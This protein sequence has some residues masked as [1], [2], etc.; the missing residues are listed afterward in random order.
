MFQNLSPNCCIT[1]AIQGGGQDEL[2]GPPRLSTADSEPFVEDFIHDGGHDEL[3]GPP[4][5]NSVDLSS[6]AFI[7]EGGQEELPGPP[8]P[9]TAARLATVDSSGDVLSQEGGQEELPGPPRS[10]R[11][12]LSSEDFIQ[13][14]GHD[15]LPGPPRPSTVDSLEITLLDQTRRQGRFLLIGGYSRVLTFPLPR[16]AVQLM[17]LQSTPRLVLQQKDISSREA[18]CGGIGGEGEPDKETMK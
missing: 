6:E 11:V 2:P 16:V 10:S 17:Y 4:R 13:E 9:E 3:P 18:L 15:E 8:L 14:G 7:Q 5:F 12:G 1:H